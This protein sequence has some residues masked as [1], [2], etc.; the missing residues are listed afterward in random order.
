[1][2]GD[3]GDVFVIPADRL[4]P[5]F[6]ERIERP[7]AEPAV[8]VPAATVV[9]LRDGA[10]GP[11]ALLM[12]RNRSSGFVPGAYVFP[13]GRVDEADTDARLL[14]AADGLAADAEPEPAFW[15]AAAREAFEETGVLL[16][17][18]ADG[19]PAPDTGADPGLAEA[20]ERL[21][22]DEITLLDVLHAA[23]LRLALRDVAYLAHWITPV[24]ERRRYDT[25]FFLARWPAGRAVAYDPREMTDARW[26]APADALDRFRAGELPMV[27]P[28]VRTL[29]SLVGFDTVDAALDAVRGRAVEPILPRLVRTD[30][31]VG[32]VVDGA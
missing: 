9:L 30:D 11:E 17:R 25:R 31:G 5:G 20:R 6:A 10:V 21:L 7:P 32:I 29:E 2:A 3:E 12:R 26:L 19:R 14:D 27:F 4:P 22:A 28:T 8:P 23:G 16:A 13:G 24:A 18:D 15:T 1:M